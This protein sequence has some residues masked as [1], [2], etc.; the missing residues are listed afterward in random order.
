MTMRAAS[1]F[2]SLLRRSV[3]V[4]STD[5]SKGFRYLH[6]L[7]PPGGKSPKIVPSPCE[8]RISFLSFPY[9]C[10]EPVLVK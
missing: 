2:R 4:M 9:V 3:P 5:T 1:A 10:P 7:H 6:A 8:T